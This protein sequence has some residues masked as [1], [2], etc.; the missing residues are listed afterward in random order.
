MTAIILASKYFF[1]NMAF[2][3]LPASTA[4]HLFCSDF[5]KITFIFIQQQQHGFYFLPASTTRLFFCSSINNMAFVLFRHQQHSFCF[6]PMSTTWLSKLTTAGKTRGCVN[7]H[8]PGSQQSSLNKRSD[9]VTDKAR[10]WSDIGPIKRH[11][12]FGHCP[13]CYRAPL[14]FV[15]WALQGT[16]RAT[17]HPSKRFDPRKVNEWFATNRLGKC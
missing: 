11:C 6:V 12:L 2:I 8:S 15:T 17:N 13:N 7:L 14:P 5:N 1:D 4:K 3:F 16:L 9:W 10:Q